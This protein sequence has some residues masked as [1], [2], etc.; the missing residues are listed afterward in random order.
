MAIALPR[1]VSD[2]GQGTPLLLLL[3]ENLFWFSSLPEKIPNY[4]S[5]Q[6]HPSSPVTCH[7]QRG[8]PLLPVFPVVDPLAIEY[9]KVGTVSASVSICHTKTSPCILTSDIL[10]NDHLMM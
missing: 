2:D 8:T 5:A 3:M 1:N 7:S 4:L 9:V 10:S 6:I